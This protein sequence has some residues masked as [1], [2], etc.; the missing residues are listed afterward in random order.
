[1]SYVKDVQSLMKYP[2]LP[3]INKTKIL[4]NIELSLPQQLYISKR[5]SP[6]DS[7]LNV[8]LTWERGTG[9]SFAMAIAYIEELLHNYQYKNNY[10][11]VIQ[12]HCDCGKNSTAN[13][14]LV[15][16]IREL[17]SK[18][19]FIIHWYSVG[20]FNKIKISRQ[21]KPKNKHKEYIYD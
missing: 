9:Q 20:A 12:D 15:H 13:R 16:K 18:D 11:I 1:M 10:S 14:L 17:L 6:L 4:D 21:D 3:N 7:K 2:A 5:F 19:N 8:T